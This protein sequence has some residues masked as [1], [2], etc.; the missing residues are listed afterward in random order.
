MDNRG[1]NFETYWEL[2]DNKAAGTDELGSSF[3]KRLA[4]L[5]AVMGFCSPILSD[6]IYL[7]CFT[8]LPTLLFIL[9]GCFGYVYN[10]LIWVYDSKILNCIGCQIMSI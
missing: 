10:S 6:F 2:K 5:L 8:Y 7:G 1:T 3:I 9:T 4:G